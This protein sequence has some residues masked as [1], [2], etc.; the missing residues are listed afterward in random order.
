[1]KEILDALYG[2]TTNVAT[3]Y[4]KKFPDSDKGGKPAKKVSPHGYKEFTGDVNDGTK[5][6]VKLAET[7]TIPFK[8]RIRKS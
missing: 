8:N 2:K 3:L 5:E 6:V 7:V 1:M 4:Q